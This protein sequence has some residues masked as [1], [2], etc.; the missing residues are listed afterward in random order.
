MPVLR[1][2]SCSNNISGIGRMGSRHD[3]FSLDELQERQRAI[4]GMIQS[5]MSF[6]PSSSTNPDNNQKRNSVGNIAGGVSSVSSNSPSTQVKKARGRPPKSTVPPSSPLPSGPNSG[7]SLDTVIQCLDKI[8][9]QNKKL[10]NFVEVL[11]N[12]VEQ[13]TSAGSATK[14][15]GEN[16]IPPEQQSVVLAGV[17]NRLERIEQNL[18]SNTLICRGP[19]VERL[20]TET[21]TGESANLER[22][23]GKVCE[24]VCGEEVTAIDVRDLQVS[25]YGREKKSIRVS[26]TNTATK[27]HLIRQARKKKPDG[28]Y[29][30]E[31]LT[32][33]KWKL[34]KTLRQLKAQHPNKIKTV[35]TR[36]GNIFYTLSE[37]NQA[38]HVTD[39]SNWNNIINPE[40]PAENS[41]SN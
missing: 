17:N 40:V 8:N 4:D 16:P 26:C 35:F 12:K 21:A 41:S 10:L 38:V 22:L 7:I 33:S 15:Q 6:A 37:S 34:Y 19:T 11:S 29:V 30:N 36:N 9:D 5:L 3:D 31:F 1:S 14:P 2:F 25:L 13:N 18:N 27:I 20:V 23:K 28:L 32:S 24:A 39:I